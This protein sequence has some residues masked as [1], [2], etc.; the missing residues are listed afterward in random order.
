M[1]AQTKSDGD[2]LGVRIL[3][4]WA[5]CIDAQIEDRPNYTAYWLV[6]A[7]QI[8]RAVSQY[9]P[10]S[11]MYPS[12]QQAQLLAVDAVTSALEHPEES[13]LTSI[14]MPNEI[15]H[16]LG[17][18][19]LIAE[20][21]GDF[22]AGAHAEAGPIAYAEREGIPNTYCSYHRVLLGTLLSNVFEMPKLI[23]NCSVACDAN[24]LSFRAIAQRFGTEQV[25]IDVPMAYDEE[26]CAYV[27]D[28]LR[29]MA[30][31]AQD[32]FGRRLDERL[33]EEKVACSQRT[34]ELVARSLRLRAGRFI[35]NNMGLE[36]QF[37]LALHV[38]LGEPETERM[39]RTMV[40]DYLSAEPFSGVN[41]VW[42]AAAPFFCVP[43]QRIIDVNTDQQII[44]SDMCFDQVSF[45]GWEHDASEPYLA[46]AERLI[47]NSY[48]GPGSRRADRLVELCQQTNADG[49]IVFCHWG[50][51]ETMGI[52]Q[53]LVHE[54]ERAGFGAIA[55]DGDGCDRSNFPGGQAAT[56]MGAFIEMLH[57]KR[58]AREAADLAEV[59]AELTGILEG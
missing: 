23:A 52:S 59:E 57:A 20:A 10:D 34:L 9:L 3:D 54:V 13:V 39:A 4:F 56:R 58:E 37:G 26:G 47:K 35:K 44:A 30:K 55:L 11:W 51:K 5:N 49:A 12:A 6:K 48:N 19:P 36:M 40:R 50:C 2:K 17:L 46:M 15:F 43:L 27:A 7:F 25:Y 18:R 16:S 1:P 32:V 45:S 29:E 31:A 42:S 53:L 38:L 24:N 22:V 33:L 21:L 28:Q 8:K 14:F 41:I